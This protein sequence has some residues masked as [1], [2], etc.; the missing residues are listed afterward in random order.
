VLD[1]HRPQ[2]RRW[3]SADPRITTAEILRRLRATAYRGG[4]SAV[5]VLVAQ[6][7]SRL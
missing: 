5:Y 1:D 3:L 6:V 7:R 4:K 2:I